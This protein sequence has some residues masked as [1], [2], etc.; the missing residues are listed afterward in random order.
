MEGGWDGSEMLAVGDTQSL[1]EHLGSLWRGKPG[2]V[3]DGDTSD[4]VEVGVS[5]PTPNS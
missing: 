4:T 2:L 5:P 3:S 1:L